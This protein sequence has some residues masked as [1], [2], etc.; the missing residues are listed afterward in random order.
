M[1]RG[2]PPHASSLSFGSNVDAASTAEDLFAGQS[3]TAIDAS[4]SG[5]VMAA[6][7]DATGIAFPQG[8]RLQAS[9]TGVGYSKDGGASYTDLIGLRNPNPDQQWSGD[10][11]VVSI[12]GGAHFV[13]GSL[14]LPSLS[15]ARTESPLT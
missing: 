2:V 13:V 14:F 7:N 4:A 12:D 6:W 5:R 10:P 3:E 1:R 15:R 11:T 8:N 9:I